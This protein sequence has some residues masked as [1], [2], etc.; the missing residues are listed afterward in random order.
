MPQPT[1]STLPAAR[2]ARALP[3]RG[4]AGPLATLALVTAILA[5]CSG[6]AAT[7]TPGAT[8]PTA[9]AAPAASTGAGAT[10]PADAVT[11]VSASSASYEELVAALTAA[12]V[13]NAARWAN[14]VVEYR[15]YPADDPTLQK[16]QDNL[17]KYNPSP[18]TLAAILS[19]LAP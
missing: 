17:A 9:T 18:E 12:G 15:P 7:A 6:A 3:S 1:T 10:T 14:E 2:A 11:R 16:L 13:P 4:R 19:A 8:Q 5:A